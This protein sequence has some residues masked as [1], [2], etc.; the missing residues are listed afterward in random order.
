MGNQLCQVCNLGR[1]P[2]QS[3]WELQQRLVT[4]RRNNKRSDCILFLEHENVYTI[5]RAGS[6]SHIKVSESILND[7]GI[8]VIEVDRG[9]DITY[10]G[11]GQ[12]VGYPIFNLTLH[13]KDMHLYVRLLEKVLIQTLACYGIVGF[14]EAGLTGVWTAKGKI[15]AIGV[16]VKGWVSL[17]GLSLNVN[18]DMKYFNMIIPCGIT[19]R[20][21]TCMADFGVKADMENIRQEMERQF[22]AVFAVKIIPIRSIEDG[23]CKA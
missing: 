13:G 17:H 14:Q 15:G 20:A 3:A 6:R 11:P 5:G 22:A 2:Y 12:I 16:G 8:Q 18:P 9:G 21:V 7:L 10:H 4:E 23:Y 19:D 1:I